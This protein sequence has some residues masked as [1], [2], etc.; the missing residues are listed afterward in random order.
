MSKSKNKNKNSSQNIETD[1]EE[2][3]LGE[4]DDFALG[5]SDDLSLGDSEDDSSQAN[6]KQGSDTSVDIDEFYRKF[7]EAYVNSNY[8]EKEYEDFI[9]QGNL[10]SKSIYEY[11]G[12]KPF[13][14]PNDDDK[15]RITDYCAK[16]SA[17]AEDYQRTDQAKRDTLI[18]CIGVLKAFFTTN[19]STLIKERLE[20]LEWNKFE[21][22]IDEKCED[23]IVEIDEMQNLF[24][25]GLRLG[26][27]YDKETQNSFREK[28]NEEIKERDAKIESL[29]DAFKNWFQN[30]SIQNPKGVQ[31]TIGNKI[32]I[33]SAYKKYN[34]AIAF[35]N[36]EE[37]NTTDQEYVDKIETV[38][39]DLGFELKN[40]IDLLE[41]YINDYAAKHNL[42]LT[43][44]SEPDYNSF[45][46]KAVDEY[47]LSE[48]EWEDFVKAKNISY[49]SNESLTQQLVLTKTDEEKQK[50]TQEVAN[51]VLEL[52]PQIKEVLNNR[53]SDIK[54]VN[55]LIN[56][57]SK[58]IGKD[59]YTDRINNYKE[60][61]D[62]V[63]K[64][65]EHKQH[66]QASLADVNKQ[67]RKKGF[68][69]LLILI[70]LGLLGGGGFFG[71]KYIQSDAGQEKLAQI[72][73]RIQTAKENR[74]MKKLEKQLAKMAG[75][76][77][78]DFVPVEGGTFRMGSST[79]DDD[80]RPLHNVTLDSFYIC[81]HEVT[82][83]E[84]KEVMGT[85]PSAFPVDN[86]PVEQVSW[87]DAVEYC[88]KLSQK[89]GLT[90][91]Y[92]FDSQAGD[93]VCDFTAN[94]YRL[95]TEAEWEY[96]ARGGKESNAYSYSGGNAMSSLGWYKEN[97]TTTNEVMTKSANEL[98]IYDM[99]GNVW[100]W[101]WDWYANYTSED[102]TNPRGA[103][104]ISSRIFR[105]GSWY[106]EETACTPTYRGSRAPETKGTYLGFRVVRSNVAFK[107]LAVTGAA[108]NA[109]GEISETQSS[110]EQM[111]S[112]L[113]KEEAMQ[114]AQKA[115][116][117][118]A[119]RVARQQRN[120]YRTR[121]IRNFFYQLTG[122]ERIAL[123]LS[124]IYFVIMLLIA[125]ATKKFGACALYFFLPV[126]GL[127][128]GAFLGA[129]LQGKVNRE[130]FAIVLAVIG[131]II[132]LVGGFVGLLIGAV[133]GALIGY[134]LSAIV[135]IIIPIV[136]VVGLAF[137]AFF[138]VDSNYLW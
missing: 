17:K 77:L 89:L 119:K 131:G 94:G 11:F 102:V 61:T 126:I 122:F 40:P 103:S 137:L 9:L 65:H 96:A 41:E 51:K 120:E 75:M 125:L 5:E 79:G 83:A 39:K 58:W 78:E 109:S 35:I 99:S 106:S 80:E 73:A 74:A 42:D 87:I 100:E 37:D 48:K 47:S 86:H 129:F 10:N 33:A 16:L 115:Q 71:Y 19:K 52:L 53:T 62:K 14:I 2:F 15:E 68:K 45:K 59:V 32:T 82:Q 112:Q 116:A 84:W 56:E 70:I 38:L 46:N 28:L 133:V 22:T 12:L 34:K 85:N 81:K 108:D 60:F 91:C 92:K 132:G 49:I 4:S 95:P 127:I 128:G 36:A 135:F 7:V 113:E 18:D 43:K 57:A 124:G 8:R 111:R 88:N 44:L 21:T 3:S 67:K 24:K 93:Y 117:K 50:L 76:G 27:F 69:A 130:T 97:A 90:P 118:E 30:Y 104:Y 29:E 63:A 105:G 23:K 13:Q 26:L 136:F 20:T 98:G 110:I 64:L 25:N 121:N 114:Q 107:G 123:I 6:E 138:I 1:D 55:R 101:C 54:I 134:L 66:L 72:K 31:N